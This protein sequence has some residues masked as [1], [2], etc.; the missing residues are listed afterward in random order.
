MNI[1]QF[2]QRFPEYGDLTDAELADVCHQMLCDLT[3]NTDSRYVETVTVPGVETAVNEV[4]SA[5]GEV[6]NLLVK[7][8][9]LLAG[10]NTS[11]KTIS[12]KEEKSQPE[13]K[14]MSPHFMALGMQL[15]K[16]EAAILASQNDD[17]TETPEVETDIAPVPKCIGFKIIRDEL[18]NIDRVI[19]EY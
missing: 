8:N 16:I 3:D 15:S 17:T 14:D 1:K 12:T 5:V 2:R 11:L 13:M 10:M 7:V 4:N 18:G 19:P 9:N 6:A